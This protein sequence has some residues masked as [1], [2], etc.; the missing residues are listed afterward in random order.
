MRRRSHSSILALGILAS[1]SIAYHYRSLCNSERL[2]FDTERLEYHELLLDG[3]SSSALSKRGIKTILYWN[4]LFKAKDFKLGE[5]YVARHCHPDYNNCFATKNRHL[6]PIESYDA[7]LLH[8]NSGE[9][10]V[11]D[12]P[13][14]RLPH[15]KYVFV[16]LESPG[17]W[18]F[19]SSGSDD[20]WPRFAGYFNATATYQHDSDVVYSY[21]DVLPL[22]SVN[23]VGQGL[24]AESVRSILKGKSRMASWY[25]SHCKTNGRR[26]KYVTELGK[27]MPVDKF[28]RCHE[29]FVN[30][31][32]RDRDCFR[33]EVEPTYFFYLAF[34]NSLCQDYVTEKFFDALRYY[35]V[36]VVYGGAD[37]K[38]IAPPK[39][40]IDALDFD[41]PKDL[42]YY[43][44][45]LSKNLTRYGEYFEWKKRYKIVNPVKRVVCDLC[46]LINKSG[47]KTYT[48]SEWYN[49][50]RCP[51]QHKMNS[52][53]EPNFAV[54]KTK[55]NL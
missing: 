48:V 34:E 30:C 7:I 32:V 13:V 50:S 31:P 45:D 52:Q 20:I 5:G 2:K 21:A 36:P 38:K 22:E 24:D 1:L 39:S 14:K 17:N 6:L 12:L 42:A 4:G 40:Y 25:V 35:F 29:W 10:M 18:P 51:L 15:Q 16:A 28:G 37:Y 26:E 55:F 47:R 23:D 41:S 11:D 44:I 54:R 43:L 27:Y 19:N 49:S 8:G 46:K 33:D 9:L 3:D 53:M